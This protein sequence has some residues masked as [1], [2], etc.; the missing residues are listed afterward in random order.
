MT[1]EELYFVHDDRA[2]MKYK[3]APSLEISPQLR[4]ELDE[5][6]ARFVVKDEQKAAV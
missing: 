4:A 2:E 6:I 3:D 5:V 1:D